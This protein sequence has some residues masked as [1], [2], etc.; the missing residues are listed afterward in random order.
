MF[1]NA[2]IAGAATTPPNPVD[3]LDSKAEKSAKSSS[4]LLLLFTLVVVVVAGPKA[5]EKSPN[6]WLLS[7]AAL[8]LA[9]GA[10]KRSSLK[11]SIKSPPWTV[12]TGPAVCVGELI[13]KLDDFPKLAAAP[14]S[15]FLAFGCTTV[16]AGFAATVGVTDLSIPELVRVAD[17]RPEVELLFSWSLS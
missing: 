3:G 10:L 4:L 9:A 11:S 6:S 16:A 2:G 13:S 15:I 14:K 12:V 1:E 8:L 7:T 17:E 5:L